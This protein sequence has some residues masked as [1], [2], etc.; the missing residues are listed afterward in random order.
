MKTSTTIIG[1]LAT[2]TA[3]LALG[4]TDIATAQPRPGAGWRAMPFDQSNIAGWTLMTAEER[5]AYQTRMRSVQTYDECKQVQQEQ[6]QLMEARAKEKGVTL[7]APRQN[8]CDVA[9][10]RGWLK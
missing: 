6:H 2:L 5:A 7:A 4:L 3:A 8:A 10:A 1:T 9:K